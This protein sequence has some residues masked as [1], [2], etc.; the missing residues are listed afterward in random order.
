VCRR[1]ARF[2]GG[3][4]IVLSG[5]FGG[6]AARGGHFG[7]HLL[8]RQFRQDEAGLILVFGQRASRFGGR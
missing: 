3:L 8:A 2:E 6:L 7:V 4:E 1:L 5:D